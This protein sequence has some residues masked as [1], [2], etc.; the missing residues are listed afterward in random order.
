MTLLVYSQLQCIIYINNFIKLEIDPVTNVY[1]HYDTGFEHVTTQLLQVLRVQYVYTMVLVCYY[2]THIFFLFKQ[3]MF[4]YCRYVAELLFID[5]WEELIM[6][7][8][9][10]TTHALRTL[11]QTIILHE[12]LHLLPKLGHY[13][14]Y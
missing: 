10:T 6:Y 5:A 8:S 3:D 1:Y 11:G 9:L 13:T 12:L 7:V 2:D 14:N 4:V